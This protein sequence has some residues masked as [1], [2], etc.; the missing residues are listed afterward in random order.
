MTDFP[1]GERMTENSSGSSAQG[2]SD[3]WDRGGYLPAEKYLGE[4]FPGEQY[5]GAGSSGSSRSGSGGSGYGSGQGSSGYGSGQGSSGYGPGSSSGQGGSGY[6]AGSG[7]GQGGS[8]YGPGSGS[9]QGGGAGAVRPAPGTPGSAGAAGPGGATTP[10]WQ[11]TPGQGQTAGHGGRGQ[12]GTGQA[13]FGQAGFG[14][15]AFGQTATPPSGQPMASTPP[16]TARPADA[17]GF[18]GA[19]FDFSFTSF[20]TTRI[21]KV[22]Y[23]LILVLASITALIYTIV[24]FRLSAA[25]GLLTLVIGDPLF[26]IIV[27]AFWRLILE[28]FIVMFRIAEDI[29][30][31]RERSDSGAGAGRQSPLP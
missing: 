9:G 6:G 27:M 28:A 10:I 29:R 30:A 23:V 13:G 11:A 25:F 18:L 19:L 16:G 7:A 26:I 14:Q 31:L 4:Q 8:G 15:T 21:I 5:Y 3:D 22:L 24:A 1:V 20:V 17:R 2:R 12:A